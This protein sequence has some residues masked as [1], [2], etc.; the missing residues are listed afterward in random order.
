MSNEKWKNW[1]NKKNYMNKSISDFH[2]VNTGFLNKL[3]KNLR[4]LKIGTVKINFY[5]KIT[6]TVVNEISIDRPFILQAV[7]V[8]SEGHTVQD[9]LRNIELSKLVDE[10]IRNSYRENYTKKD[11][12]VIIS[13]I[14]NYFSKTK[15]EQE[16]EE[17][18]Y[19]VE[20]YFDLEIKNKEFYTK[21]EERF[22]AKFGRTPTIN[23]RVIDQFNYLGKW[24][25][26]HSLIADKI[27]SD[28]IVWGENHRYVGAKQLDLT[29]HIP[30]RNDFE[31]EEDY[32][33]GLS[34][35]FKT[36]HLDMDWYTYG[37]LPR[38]AIDYSVLAWVKLES[39]EPHQ[40]IE[41]IKINNLIPISIIPKKT[42][43]KFKD[44][45]II[46]F[47]EHNTDI[48]YETERFYLYDIKKHGRKISIDK[49]YPYLPLDKQIN[50][51]YYMNLE[52]ADMI[53]T[54]IQNLESVP[55]F[56]D[57]YFIEEDEYDI[58]NGRISRRYTEDDSFIY[59]RLSEEA[60]IKAVNSVAWRNPGF[61]TPDILNKA[62]DRQLIENPNNLFINDPIYF[63][64]MLDEVP[65]LNLE[66]FLVAWAEHNSRYDD[67]D[68]EEEVKLIL[69]INKEEHIK[70]FMIKAG[71][72]FHK[73]GEILTSG[74]NKIK[75]SP[76]F[77][78]YKRSG[79]RYMQPRGTHSSSSDTYKY[80]T[81]INENN[82]D[83]EKYRSEFFDSIRD[84]VIESF[85]SLASH[86]NL[87]ITK[88]SVKKL[89][90]LVPLFAI[91]NYLFEKGLIDYKYNNN[92]LIVEHSNVEIFEKSK[93]VIRFENKFPEKSNIQ[94]TKKLKI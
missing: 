93:E 86:K 36:H 55:N 72:V 91:E 19:L 9:N 4:H 76:D 23:H 29:L 37:V 56:E 53:H 66:E 8:E 60:K 78:I 30:R 70:D 2:P 26:N 67:E 7:V 94:K 79:K 13:N 15:S 38:V 35:S 48:L 28:D 24:D 61:I 65:S 42:L 20:E 43:K 17:F 22:E 5:D 16:L 6:K 87:I 14:S 41:L 81:I 58:Y 50:P 44:E 82:I 84:N 63:C 77:V 92:L 3:A 74:P 25:W 85:K 45:Q 21:Y 75:V 39:I 68:D 69:P 59:D 46:D 11:L 47:M 88:E 32:D 49:I 64:S 62:M 57:R 10:R 90:S 73:D 51:D 89:E 71:C 27:F 80:C 40:W 54:S 12:E 1:Q 83:Y 33:E 18:E 34:K 52:S 31:D